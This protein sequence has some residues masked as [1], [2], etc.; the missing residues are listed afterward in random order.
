MEAPLKE[1]SPITPQ[2]PVI[3]PGITYR[4]TVELAA[5]DLESSE[6][7][8]QWYSYKHPLPF[9]YESRV[10]NENVAVLWSSQENLAQMEFEQLMISNGFFLPE[11]RCQIFIHP[12]FGVV[13]AC[14]WNESML[15][16]A[17]EEILK[18]PSKSCDDSEVVIARKFIFAVLK[19]E[20]NAFE[21]WAK[22][23]SR[24]LNWQHPSTLTL[25]MEV[26]RQHCLLIKLA[27]AV[28]AV[29]WSRSWISIEHFR[30]PHGVRVRTARLYRFLFLRWLRDEEHTN[31]NVGDVDLPPNIGLDSHE[32]VNDPLHIWCIGPEHREEEEKGEEKEMVGAPRFEEEVLEGEG[33]RKKLFEEE[34]S[35]V[36]ENEIARDKNDLRY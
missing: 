30:L 6:L 22:I 13:R 25:H 27:N 28:A 8:D 16:V 5:T 20:E 29:F 12:C 14:R 31:A 3:I 7:L 35:A 2:P 10:T 21:K 24:E 9:S 17:G 23:V 34:E 32:L 26:Y 18:G 4:H 11:L 33:A 1:F 36:V 19:W 15:K